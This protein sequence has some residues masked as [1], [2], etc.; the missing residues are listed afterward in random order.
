MAMKAPLKLIGINLALV[1]LIIGA[2]ELIFG[3]WIGDN[4]GTLVIPRD[5]SR[6]FDVKGLY[7]NPTPT[8]YYRR[9]E[10]GLRGQ[11]GDLSNIDILTIGGSTTNEV[12][13]EEGKTWSDVLA[14]TF[15]ENRQPTTVVN[16]GVDGQS[17]IGH[18]KNFELWFP[19]ISGLR[20][21]FVLAYVGINDLA[22]AQ[23]G[24]L[25]KQDHMTAQRRAVK[26]YLMNNS[27]LYSLFR[28]IRG[29]I[30]ARQANVIHSS[31]N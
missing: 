1:A 21:R 15:A 7:D 25:G 26:Q 14:R 17:T 6:R 30:R 22:I 4:Y 5:F 9:D 10:H 12:F 28:N 11:Y 29:M 27:A 31:K 24:H 16:A 2:A 20:A 23:S 3:G 18:I 8:I 13:V 19:K